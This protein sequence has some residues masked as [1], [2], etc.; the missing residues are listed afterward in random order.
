MTIIGN[1]K[2]QAVRAITT[3]SFILGTLLQVNAI[4]GGVRH[5]YIAYGPQP[6]LFTF[7]IICQA[8]IQMYW[9]TQ[10]FPYELGGPDSTL[11]VPENEDNS[12]S[13]DDPIQVAEPF[14][15]DATQLA[16]SPI[17]V[18]GN[19]LLCMAFCVTAIPSFAYAVVYHSCMELFLDTGEI[20]CVSSDADIQ[21]IDSPL[22]GLCTSQ[23]TT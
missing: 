19:I 15:I 9:L 18:L 12:E 10:L 16:Y 5:L 1:H 4:L 6:H 21:H 23:S 14:D 2:L 17:F 8:I 20:Y 7:F 3:G 13:E 22:C 11:L